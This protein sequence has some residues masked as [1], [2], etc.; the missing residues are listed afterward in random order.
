MVAAESSLIGRRQGLILNVSD[1][2]ALIQALV[3]KNFDLVKQRVG[4]AAS[5]GI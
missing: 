4:A 1:R 2:E 5:Q 3:T